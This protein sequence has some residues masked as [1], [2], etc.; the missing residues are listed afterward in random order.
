MTL[1]AMIALSLAVIFT[2]LLFHLS[3]DTSRILHQTKEHNALL[4]YYMSGDEDTDFNLSEYSQLFGNLQS[5]KIIT[6]TDTISKGS[7]NISFSRADLLPD[8]N[9][10]NVINNPVCSV[11]FTSNKI[12]GDFDYLHDDYSFKQIDSNDVVLTRIDL[13]I[14]PLLSL[15]DIEVRGNMAYVSTDSTT[16]ADLDLIVFDISDKTHPSVISSINTGPG[17]S[18]IALAGPRIYAGATSRAGQ[19]HVIDFSG[20]KNL[21]LSNVF[22]L[23]L[24]YATTTPPLAS[25]ITYHDGLVYLGTEKWDGNELNVIDPFIRE[26]IGG[27]EADSKIND[28]YINGNDLYLSGANDVQMTML[29]ISDPTNINKMTSFIESGWQRQDVTTTSI[30]EEQMMFARTS[31]GFNLPND[32]ELF[33]G[34]STRIFSDEA[35]GIYGLLMDRRHLYLGTRTPNREF[36]IKDK[37]D[38]GRDIFTLPLPIKVEAMTCDGSDIYILAGS[39]PIIY[40]VSF[41]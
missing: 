23:P 17:I 12:V 19:L 39:A 18:S 30:F 10:D 26:V 24:P 29:D 36:V 13:P 35:G 5:E 28:I 4:D 32:Y 21:T 6:I 11:D 38:L 1:D 2:S 3:Q 25:A 37:N 31:G 8:I 34:T 20:A 33:V 9:T 22:K 27:Y 7:E 14:D 15:T 16:Q 41:K 40:K